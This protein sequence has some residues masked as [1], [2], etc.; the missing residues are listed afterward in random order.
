MIRFKWIGSKTLFIYLSIFRWAV[1]Q[2][3]QY[4]DNGEKFLLFTYQ[5][6]YSVF[7]YTGTV[8]VWYPTSEP[9]LL[10]KKA[11]LHREQ[12]FFSN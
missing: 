1:L 8:P 11:R 3:V 7:A 5:T 6:D 12:I 10:G 4:L 2:Q 9:M